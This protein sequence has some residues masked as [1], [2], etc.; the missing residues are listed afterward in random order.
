MYFRSLFD[1]GM[2]IMAYVILILA[3][4]A[5]VIRPLV[6]NKTSLE[7]FLTYIIAGNAY[8]IF[9][10][11]I[12]GYLGV[13]N[14][15]TFGWTMV[16]S[17]LTLR[18]IID[19]KSFIARILLGYETVSHLLAGEYGFGLYA[20][21][22][23]TNIG[24]FLKG[25]WLNLF[26][27][28]LT[29]H[30][31][32]LGLVI[33]NMYYFGYNSLKFISY[34]AP[35]EEVHLYWIQSML[36]GNIYPSGVYPHGFHNIVSAISVSFNIR[37]NS[38][39]GVFGIMN[40]ALLLI[41]LYILL[42]KV[43]SFKPAALLGIVVFTFLN[44]FNIEAISRFQYAIPQEYGMVVLVPMILFLLAY[45]ENRKLSD[46]LMFGL[47]F[48]LTIVF[49]FYVTVIAFMICLAIGLT[50][51][52]RIFKKKLFLKIIITGLLS[53]C[54][55]FL[56]ILTGMALGYPLEQS[57]GW[58]S[59]VISGDV[60]GDDDEA[61]YYE[62]KT[63]LN[64]FKRE[65]KKHAFNELGIFY[66]FLGILAVAWLY[67]IYRK[68]KEPDNKLTM[69][70]LAMIHMFLIFI[71]LM[72]SRA[73]KIPTIMET[74]RLVIFFAYFSSFIVA[75]PF[76]LIYRFFD[77]LK[78]SYVIALFMLA[79]TPLVVLTLTDYDLL[80]EKPNFY[81]FQTRGAMF[82]ND[83]IMDK[84]P[85]NKWTVVSP[86]NDLSALMN[87]GFHYEL[88]DLVLEQE[89]YEPDIQIEIPTKYVFIYIEK[90][91]INYYGFRFF[92]DD[93]E[94]TK[95]PH[96]TYE[97]AS[98]TIDNSLTKEEVYSQQRNVVMAKAY[99]WAKQYQK[100]FPHEMLVYY[101]DDE[102]IVYRVTQN[103]FALN[104]FAIDYGFNQ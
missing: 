25:I 79:I 61:E 76:D 9:V 83:H 34:G 60:Y 14:G 30:M 55:G 100:F 102:I 58:A 20:Q 17:G 80:R 27:E 62:I 19:R 66:L 18:Y 89:G 44:L 24:T 86:V 97:D 51:V 67:N 90:R 49:H 53:T 104:N 43:I 91:P 47:S 42:K 57:I 15:N 7:R 23:L 2:I 5:F 8:V 21:N 69:Y 1:L 84:Y 4:P 31:V 26:G 99:Y 35:D 32:F 29:E 98:L 71:F 88:L 70:Q 68:F 101:E 46:L 56:P 22:K 85:D 74:K 103:E 77:R 6:K 39:I 96:V 52:V 72:A 54:L 94:I 16:I 64:V 37:A 95:R 50:F 10:V 78:M 13:L 28:S 45:I 33:Y 12:L 75:L 73:L 65:I 92:E 82:V 41:M 93:P 81:Y 63:P 48:A 40:V 11:Y 3:Y 59:S 87:K 38:I 36:S